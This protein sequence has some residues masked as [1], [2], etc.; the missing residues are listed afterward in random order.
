[1]TTQALNLRM[2]DMEGAGHQEKFA[3]ER[4][5]GCDGRT[6]RRRRLTESVGP[7]AIRSLFD[8]VFQTPWL[9]AP[10]CAIIRGTKIRDAALK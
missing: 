7:D 1:M 9:I 10:L 3:I 4:S 2:E 5:V 8:L 6:C